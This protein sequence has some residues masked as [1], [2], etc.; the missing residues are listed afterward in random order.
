MGVKDARARVADDRD[1]DDLTPE[2]A[3]AM[4]AE[5]VDKD[6]KELV[7]ARLGC[8]VQQVVNIK[9]GPSAGGQDPG[10]RNACAI[11]EVYKIPMRSWVP[12]PA[13]K[14]IK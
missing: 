10:L 8:S 11:E 5:I 12:R 9:K 2:K 6:G 13:A 7:A 1:E 3:R 14:E 4:F